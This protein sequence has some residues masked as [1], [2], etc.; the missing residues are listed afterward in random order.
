M[1]TWVALPS[2][3]HLKPW[4][5]WL[6][7]TSMGEHFVLFKF[8]THRHFFSF[9]NVIPVSQLTRAESY[10]STKQ[11]IQ[12]VDDGQWW[13]YFWENAESLALI[14]IQRRNRDSRISRNFQMHWQHFRKWH[15]FHQVDVILLR[16]FPRA[17]V[18]WRGINVSVSS[19]C[20][21]CCCW[22]W[23]WWWWWWLS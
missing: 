12:H 14:G 22:W 23:W 6:N 11:G 16:P 19:R 8:R 20:C 7:S 18:A 3:I 21:C 4:M 5:K 17:M 13:T 1:T 10:R 15:P 9:A 2:P